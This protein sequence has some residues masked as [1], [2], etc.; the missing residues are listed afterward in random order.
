M[1]R[2][3]VLGFLRNDKN[4]FDMEMLTKVET[5]SPDAAASFFGFL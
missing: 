2:T 3:T 5:H 1:C 4:L